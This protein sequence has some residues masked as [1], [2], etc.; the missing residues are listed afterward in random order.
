MTRGPRDVAVTGLAMITPGGPTADSTWDSMCTGQSLART[1]PHLTGLPVDISCHI[2]DFDAFSELGRP[3]ARRLDR[4]AHLTL[5]AARQAVT[6]AKLDP[7]HW[8]SE[9]VGVILGVG[10]NSL[11]NYGREF[12]L[13]TQGRP[14]AVSPMALPRSVPNMVAA[15]VSLDLG[16]RGPGFTVASACAG[17]ATAIAVARQLLLAGSCDIVLTGSGESGRCRMGA[18]CF[19][20]LGALSRRTDDPASACRPFDRQRDGFVLS[21]GAAI[22]ALELP[23]H[24]VR[25]GARI[26]ALLRGCASSSDAYHPVAP[27]PEGDGAERAIRAALADAGCTPADVGHVNTHGTSTPAGDAAEARVLLRVFGAAPPPVTASKSVLGHALGA[28][29]AIEAALTVLT[30]ERRQIP[31]T[32]NCHA[33]DDGRA[34]DV[35]TGQPRTAE[36][37]VAISSSFGFGGQNTV[38]VLTT[39]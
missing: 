4:T 9:R 34:L 11:Q 8:P 21:E 25:R 36:I 18:T 26:R 3:L 16:A 10:G 30:L 22:L 7:A 27:H 5:V 38:L 19:S 31:P 1:D 35:V 12:A 29:A 6:D 39:P 23:D 37:D 2:D 15:E 14:A 24:A 20:Q 28:S 32:A 13:L 17:G 33:Q